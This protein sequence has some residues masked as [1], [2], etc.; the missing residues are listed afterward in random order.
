MIEIHP[1]TDKKTPPPPPPPPSPSPPPPPPPPPTK[2][3]CI[4]RFAKYIRHY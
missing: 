1:K 2:N 3:V 4:E